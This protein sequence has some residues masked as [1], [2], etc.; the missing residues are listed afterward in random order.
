MDLIRPAGGRTAGKTVPREAYMPFSS[1]PR[2][3]TG[4]GFAMIEGVL[5]VGDDG[6]GVSL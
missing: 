2:V 1:G 6:A 5:L 4:A 3:C